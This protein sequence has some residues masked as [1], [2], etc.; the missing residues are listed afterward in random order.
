MT[1]FSDSPDMTAHDLERNLIRVDRVTRLFAG[2][3]T[4]AFGQPEWGATG[5]VWT[6][7][8]TAM[9]DPDHLLRDLGTLGLD[10][11]VHKHGYDV[12][13]VLPYE[14]RGD[15]RFK[16]SVAQLVFALAFAANLI[17]ALWRTL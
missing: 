12:L 15:P 4:T 14:R 5:F 10:A 2:S 8:A 11:E 3:Q 16:L 13:V 7:K 9:C 17:W 1:H 6:M